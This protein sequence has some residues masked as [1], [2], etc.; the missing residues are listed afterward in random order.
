[1]AHTLHVVLSTAEVLQAAP[2]E[3]TFLAHSS[4]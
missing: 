3:P 4:A 2:E 1:M